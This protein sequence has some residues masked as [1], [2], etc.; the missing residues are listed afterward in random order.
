MC[1]CW[2]QEES[3]C[4]S[5]LFEKLILMKRIPHNDLRTYEQVADSNNQDYARR[6]DSR[7]NLRKK[8]ETLMKRNDLNKKSFRIEISL[9]TLIYLK[10]F[11]NEQKGKTKKV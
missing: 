3:D 10:S 7:R 8:L 2:E 9:V 11:S 6:C 5:V 1:K 4:N